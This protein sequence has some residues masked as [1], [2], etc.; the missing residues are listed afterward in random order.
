M[1]KKTKKLWELMEEE[2][3]WVGCVDCIFQHLQDA[4]ANQE[5]SVKPM[6][7]E[8]FDSDGVY[9]NE[10]VFGEHAECG[11]HFCLGCDVRL[12]V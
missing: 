11:E 1:E 2:S 6:F 8:K 10:D 9:A 4:Y 5:I 12:V 3:G 7:N